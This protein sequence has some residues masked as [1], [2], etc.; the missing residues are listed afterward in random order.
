MPV[1]TAASAGTLGLFGIDVTQVFA[2]VA[3]RTSDL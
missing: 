3:I 1:S 2:D